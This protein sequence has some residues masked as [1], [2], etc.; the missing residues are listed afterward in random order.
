MPGR[1]M[2]ELSSGI[3]LHTAKLENEP[4]LVFKSNE[5]VNSGVIEEIAEKTVIIKGKSYIKGECTFK[6]AK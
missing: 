1:F 3:H 4:V 5:L 2:K 6:Y